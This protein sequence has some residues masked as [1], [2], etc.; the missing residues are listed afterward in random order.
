MSQ[1]KSFHTSL[2]GL[3]GLLALAVLFLDLLTK[4]LVVLAWP[5]PFEH[6]L[7]IIPGFFR[8]VHWRNTGAAWGIFAGHTWL[9]TA[10]SAAACILLAVFFNKFTGKRPLT[11][12][13]AG[14]LLGGIAGNFIDRAFYSEG[15]IDFLR[16]R[17]F[18]AFNIADSAITCSIIFIIACELFHKEKP[19]QNVGP[20]QPNS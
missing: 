16:F 9:L 17:S 13:P 11:A 10:I 14:L 8:L 1:P 2:F 20:S 18:P 3:P 4:W 6:D 15:V 7:V 19:A 5:E 12:I